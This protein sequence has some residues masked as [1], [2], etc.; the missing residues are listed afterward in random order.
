MLALTL[1]DFDLENNTVDINKSFT[2]LDKKDIIQTPKT[3]KS[4]RRISYK[5]RTRAFACVF[6]LKK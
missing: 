3:P 5:K 2:R 1:K 4:K 6:I